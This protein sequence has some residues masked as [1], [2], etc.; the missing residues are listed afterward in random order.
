MIPHCN[1]LRLLL[2]GELWTEL[3]KAAGLVDLTFKNRTLHFSSNNSYY[4]ISVAF[5]KKQT[6]DPASC[7][8]LTESSLARSSVTLLLFRKPLF[9]YSPS[10][11]PRFNL[12][13]LMV[14]SQPVCVSTFTHPH[15]SKVSEA[16]YRIC[17]CGIIELL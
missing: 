16:A 14:V 6:Q 10:C 7:T 8:V 17:L 12:A 1:Q 15:G 11:G 5:G 3:N 2:F 4:F 13:T 9:P